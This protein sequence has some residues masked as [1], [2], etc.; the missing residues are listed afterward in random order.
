[1]HHCD[2]LVIGGGMVGAAAANRLARQGRDVVLLDQSEPPDYERNTLPDLRVSA[3]SPGSA[4]LLQACEC[5]ATITEQRVSEYAAMEVCA[6]QGGMIQF[7]AAEH[8]LEQLGWIIENRLIQSSLWQHLPTSVQTI[9]GQRCVAVDAGSN[10]MIVQLDNQETVIARLVIAADG[11]RSSIREMLGIISR[12]KDYAQRGVVAILQSEIPNPGIA[13]QCFL[14]TGPL[15]FLPLNDGCSSM[16][17]SLPESIAADKTA[18]STGQ[19]AADITLKSNARFGQITLLTKAVS[20]PLQLQLA[21]NMLHERVVLLGDAAHQVHP[22]AGQGVN[23]GFADVVELSSCLEQH[24]L[25]SGLGQ[26]LQRFERRRI[27]ENTLMAKGIDGLERLFN[28]FPGIASM[29]LQWVNPVWPIK[30]Q[31]IRRACGLSR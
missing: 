21:S 22:L 10:E 11:A 29:G 26:Q 23:L 2:V 13:W 27:S 18:A 3:I 12:H 6:E 7:Q 24:D 28:R 30:D 25:G 19:L 14:D 1:M 9:N 4:A 17:W 16:V 5:W 20:F 15:A 8:G 31:F